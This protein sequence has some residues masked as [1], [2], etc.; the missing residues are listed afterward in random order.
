MENCGTIYGFGSRMKLSDI[1]DYP[2]PKVDEVEI[3]PVKVEN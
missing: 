2:K 1:A 3:S